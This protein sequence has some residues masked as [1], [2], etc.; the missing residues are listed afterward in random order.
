MVIMYVHAPFVGKWTQIVGVLAT[1]GKVKGDIL[2]TI[3]IEAVII[4]E[5]AY[6]FVDY[7]TC[8]GPSWNREM[9]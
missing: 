3:L 4:A 2:L 6:L 7:I 5:K 8:D 1:K 9:W